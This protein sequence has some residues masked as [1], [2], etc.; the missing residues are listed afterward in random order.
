MFKKAVPFFIK[1]ITPLHAGTGQELGIVDLPIQRERHTGLPKIESSGVKGSIR[2]VFREAF[3]EEKEKIEVAFGPEENPQHAATLGFTEARLLLFP[4]KSAMGIFA[5][6]T[7]PMVLRR[8]KRE[9]SLPGVSLGKPVPAIPDENTVGE[10]SSLL[11]QYGQGEKAVVLEEFTFKVKEDE[12]TTQFAAWLKGYAGVEEAPQRLVVLPDDD[13][14]TLVN[15][16]TE[17]ITRIKIEPETGTVKE[18][19][20]FTEEFLPSETVLYSLALATP[21]SFQ[22]VR[23]HFPGN[24]PEEVADSI[25]NFFLKIPSF[26]Q[27]GGDATI[28]KGI[29]QIIRGGGQ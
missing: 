7:C 5:L 10:N 2:E 25:L 29:V 27:I 19:A 8:L 24:T 26:I 28:G 13:F 20:L 6:T 16:T 21:L 23:E 11:L 1:I 9:L 14:K 4:V 3:P 12:K 18:G 15:L 22:Q 17:V